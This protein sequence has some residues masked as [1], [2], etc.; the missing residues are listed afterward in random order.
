VLDIL[1]ASNQEVDHL[2]GIVAL[3]V[4]FIVVGLLDCI[5]Y[6]LIPRYDVVIIILMA[7]EFTV[8]Y[9]VGWQPIHNEYFA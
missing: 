3:V 4:G 2:F 8:W 5:G 7:N 6:M 1:L 9:V